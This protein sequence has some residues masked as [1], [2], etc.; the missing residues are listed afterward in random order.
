MMRHERLPI[1]L[2]DVAMSGDARLAAEVSRKLA[3]VII[4]DDDDPLALAKDSRNLVRMERN[5]PLDLKLVGDDPLFGS[6]FLDRFANNALG[7]TPSHQRH[8]RFLRP[9]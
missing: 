5:D 2:P 8:L 4:L 3:S 7:R 9:E 1:V 6:Q